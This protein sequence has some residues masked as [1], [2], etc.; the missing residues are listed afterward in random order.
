MPTFVLV[1]G[2]T[3]IYLAGSGKLKAMVDVL[4]TPNP[5]VTNGGDES[6]SIPPSSGGGSATFG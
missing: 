4:K 5:L 2:L 1:L 6:E 3:L